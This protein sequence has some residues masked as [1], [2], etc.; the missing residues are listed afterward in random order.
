MANPDPN[1]PRYGTNE[2]EYRVVVVD[3]PWEVAGPA[4]RRKV[5]PRAA[6]AGVDSQWEAHAPYDRMSMARVLAM[7]VRRLCA[8]N[9]WVCLW[10]PTSLAAQA[11]AV[12]AAWGVRTVGWRVWHKT[13]GGP[14]LPGR[15]CVD[16]EFVLVGAVGKP[17]WTTCRGFRAVF[18]AP[19]AV[20][21]RGDAGHAEHARKAIA[22]GATF[23]P[24]RFVHSAK[25]PEFYEELAMRTEGPRVDLFARRVHAG[26]DGW[27][28]QYQ[29][30]R[31]N[32]DVN[33]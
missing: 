26:F 3:P 11:P 30:E 6:A 8:P 32:W 31:I 17:R 21:S 28:D 23:P 25:P 4:L 29:G 15:W 33:P 7:P 27:G 19:R 13:N 2:T 18:Q 24:P 5:G 14:Q 9:A 20:M 22:H 1:E 16:C 10:V 12:L